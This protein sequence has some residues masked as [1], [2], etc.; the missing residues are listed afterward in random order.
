MPAGIGVHYS[1]WATHHLAEHYRMGAISI[2][3]YVL[4]NCPTVGDVM[5]RQAVDEKAA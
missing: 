5:P 1:S 4:L 3:G 2:L